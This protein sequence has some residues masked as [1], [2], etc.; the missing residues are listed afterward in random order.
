VSTTNGLI[1]SE[2]VQAKL[3]ESFATYLAAAPRDPKADDLHAWAETRLT[4]LTGAEMFKN[5][6]DIPETK[7]LM[8]FGFMVYSQHQDVRL[9]VSRSMPVPTALS[10]LE[11]DFFPEL[12]HQI[13]VNCLTSRAF[14]DQLV[15]AG[16]EVERFVARASST[17][18]AS[19][20]RDESRALYAVT[21][22]IIVFAGIASWVNSKDN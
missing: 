18:T 13:E 19:M 10:K 14:G 5:A 15:A 17:G 21:V 2:G 22:V 11:P 8:S 4:D 16:A 1:N 7:T 3:D 9:E 6:L 20:M 12:L